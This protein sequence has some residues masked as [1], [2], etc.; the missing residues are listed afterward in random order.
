MAHLYALRSNE[1]QA[2]GTGAKK[3]RVA[4]KDFNIW[5][6]AIQMFDQDDA[7]QMTMLILILCGSFFAL[8]GCDEHCDLSLS[9]IE[10]DDYTLGSP[11]YGYKF[12]GITN[13]T[14]KSHKLR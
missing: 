7:K 14:D 1:D 5:D 6:K 13:L 9:N 3:Q 2:Y 10:I 12:I 8:R 4:S 11:F